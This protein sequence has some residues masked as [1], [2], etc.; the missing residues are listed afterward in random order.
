MAFMHVGLESCGHRHDATVHRHHGCLLDAYIAARG[1]WGLRCLLV[2]WVREIG[3]CFSGGRVVF[4]EGCGIGGFFFSF[5]C[6]KIKREK[7]SSQG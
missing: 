3:C 6:Y 4:C 5:Q 7:G 1:V 2:E